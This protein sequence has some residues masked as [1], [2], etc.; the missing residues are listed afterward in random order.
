[1]ANRK[2]TIIQK[3]H[4]TTQTNKKRLNKTIPTT[5]IE[6][7]SGVSKR[8]IFLNVFWNVNKD[9]KHWSIHTL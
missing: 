2:R 9:G 6:D 5:K 3:L 8:L 1:M 4:N 7:N